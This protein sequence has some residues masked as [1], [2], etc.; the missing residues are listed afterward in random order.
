MYRLNVSCGVCFM[1]SSHTEVP[2][3]GVAAFIGFA[4]Q[5]KLVR[6]MSAG[7][8]VLHALPYGFIPGDARDRNLIGRGV[9]TT[10]PSGG[11]FCILIYA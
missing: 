6:F 5:A 3:F 11:P 4:A 8:S 1:G 7:A 10:P 9:L 2:E